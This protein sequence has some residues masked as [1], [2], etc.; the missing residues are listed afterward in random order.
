MKTKTRTKTTKKKKRKKT[1]H[2]GITDNRDYIKPL[3]SIIS[4]STIHNRQEAKTMTKQQLLSFL[5]DCQK[6]AIKQHE[7]ETTARI[8]HLI[9]DLI[10][11]EYRR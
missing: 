2:K 11:K 1:T 5:F 4:L 10:D 3:L 6:L 9:A 7:H 8:T